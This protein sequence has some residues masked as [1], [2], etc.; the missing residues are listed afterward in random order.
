MCAAAATVDPV[1]VA[2]RASSSSVPRA[3]A[4]ALLACFAGVL[5]AAVGL[6]FSQDGV[7]ALVGALV[8]LLGLGIPAAIG[9]LLATIAR[10]GAHLRRRARGLDPSAVVRDPLG[11]PYMVRGLLDGREVRLYR[12]KIEVDVTPPLTG[13]LGARAL[14][15]LADGP[16][17]AAGRS[18]FA[19]SA[20]ARRAAAR[21]VRWGVRGLELGERKV[22]IHGGR[23]RAAVLA[24][25]ALAVALA[26]A[27]IR[28]SPSRAHGA[29]CP[30]CRQPT[31]THREGPLMR[32][33][34]CD[35]QHH[36]DCWNDHGGCAVFRCRRGPPPER[37]ARPALTPPATKSA[38]PL[39][40]R[41][42]A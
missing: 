36:A 33:D 9:A 27:R 10:R 32:C 14:R 37:V 28:F 2:E 40:P 31:G 25:H 22:V 23:G 17:A 41:Q 7:R 20:D 26:P 12:G 8:L 19:G 38:P 6:S 35:G 1:H 34:A 39:E 21:L 24:R 11:L 30:Y 16:V 15:G 29:D 13:R 5:V 18:S 4:A 42:R 3:L